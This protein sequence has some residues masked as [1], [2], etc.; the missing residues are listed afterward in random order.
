MKTDRKWSF[1]WEARW[2]GGHILEKNGQKQTCRLDNFFGGRLRDAYWRRHCLV[3]LGRLSPMSS[4]HTRVHAI[5]LRSGQLVLTVSL[6]VRKDTQVFFFTSTSPSMCC[7][8]W[9]HILNVFSVFL[10]QLTRLWRLV[11]FTS[12]VMQIPMFFDAWWIKIA[13]IFGE[14]NKLLDGNVFNQIITFD[15]AS[16]EVIHTFTDGV[17]TFATEEVNA[18]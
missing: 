15:P 7:G 1:A 18:Q 14:Y 11:R 3:G 8:I 6:S 13:W 9:E 5:V 4:R 2:K 10:A 16:G 17:D 12:V